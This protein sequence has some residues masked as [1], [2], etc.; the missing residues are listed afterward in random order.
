M[1]V[2]ITLTRFVREREKDYAHAS[3]DFT[4]LI[5]EIAHA[6]RLISREVNR[7]GLADILGLTGRIN[8]QGEEVQKLDDLAQAT[9]YNCLDHTHLVCAMASEE[10]EDILQIP[11]K[12]HPLGK[13]VLNFDPLDGSGNIDVNASIGT[14]IGIYHR[15]SRGDADAPATLEDVLQ[16]GRDQVAAIYVIYG[17]S[18]VLIYC[19]GFGVHE[20]TLDPSV[21]E[22][23]LSQ[24]DIRIPEQGKFYSINEGYVDYWSQDQ[25]RM[26]EHFRTA[27]EGRKPYGLRYIGSLVADFH[28]TLKKGGIFMYP[29]DSRRASGKLRVLFE[30]NPLAFIARTAG[31]LASDGQRDILDIRPEAVHQ[32]T[33]LFIGSRKDVETAL[34]FLQPQGDCARAR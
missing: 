14:I 31:G 34:R 24:E 9:L 5:I 12:H 25:R 17:S 3:G 30:A 1:Q 28:R 4:G 33:P 13:Y 15:V 16:K 11:A 18:T 2:G 8:V 23:Y 10:E 7:A 27:V 22:F 26:V 20:F 29:G 6:T 19:D 32:R 21:G